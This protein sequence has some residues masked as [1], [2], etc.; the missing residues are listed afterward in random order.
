MTPGMRSCIAPSWL[1]SLLNS[2]LPAKS[3]ALMSNSVFA[4]HTEIMVR[5]TLTHIISYSLAISTNLKVCQA[6]KFSG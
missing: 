5:T 6:A 4:E 2:S 1:T 3:V